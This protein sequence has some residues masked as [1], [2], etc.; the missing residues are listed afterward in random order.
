M[1][2]VLRGKTVFGVGFLAAALIHGCSSSPREFRSGSAGSGESGEAPISDSGR[3]SSA[4]SGSSGEG[5]ANDGGANDGG[6]SDGGASG[7]ESGGMSG[8]GGSAGADCGEACACDGHPCDCAAGD[9][10]S[11]ADGG[12]LGSC[13]AG[14]Q[15]CG[16]DRRWGACNIQAKGK[17]TCASGNDDTCN[18]VVNEGCPCVEGQTRPCSDGGLVGK[19]AAGRQTCAAAT[20]GA[21]SI[22][23]ATADTCVLGNNDNCS[24]PANEGCLCIE[25]VTTRPCGVCQDGSQTCSSGKTGQYGACSGGTTMKTY[26][27]DSDGDGH[28][29]NVAT[30]VCG[31]AP[32]KYITGPV[33]DC[34]DS[35]E[36]AFPGQ[37]NAFS[38]TRGDGSYDYNCNNVEEPTIKKGDAAGC[39]GCMTTTSGACECAAPGTISSTPA[40]GASFG[41]SVCYAAPS[42]GPH[43]VAAG[44]QSCK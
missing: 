10:R 4:G 36:N 14:T 39:A 26:Y 18:G 35:N 22:A 15:A 32:A 37:T 43:G 19:C 9:Q 23:P 17:D 40:C 12:L 21:C 6:A 13:A 34:Y 5:G 44:P 25:G 8:E 11:C 28:A 41:V 42:C 7:A 29:V 20:W 16:T 24:G 1:K 2:C 31:A 30:T 27:L 3:P 33:D 38:V